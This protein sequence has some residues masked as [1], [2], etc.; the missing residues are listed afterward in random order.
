M[1]T[2]TS[3]ALI[4]LAFV[5]APVSATPLFGIELAKFSVIAADY[6]TYGAGAVVSGQVGAVTYVTA[7]AGGVSAGDST[8]TLNAEVTTALGQLGSAQAALNKM[9]AGTTLA[10]TMAGHTTLSA[11]V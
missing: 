7:G 8:A 5:L 1:K 9:G 2:K 6:A 11:G 3:L 4:A 10:P